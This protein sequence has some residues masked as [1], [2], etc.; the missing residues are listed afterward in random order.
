LWPRGES[1]EDGRHTFASLLVALGVGRQAGLARKEAFTLL[2]GRKGERLRRVPRAP[3][4]SGQAATDEL[5]LNLGPRRGVL[6]R[7]VTDVVGPDVHEGG[8]A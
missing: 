2:R 4:Q 3:A 1:L 5:R 8:L 7:P 6:M